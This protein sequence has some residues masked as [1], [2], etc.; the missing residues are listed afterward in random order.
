[1]IST[2]TQQE[3]AKK[4]DVNYSKWKNAIKH[5]DAKDLTESLQETISVIE[6]CLKIINENGHVL[7]GLVKDKKTE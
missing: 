2:L 4:M 6:L 7:T 5:G 3:R 1:M